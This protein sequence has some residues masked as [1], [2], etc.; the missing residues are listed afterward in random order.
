M[1]DSSLPNPGF[2]ARAATA[3]VLDVFGV[4]VTLLAGG[5]GTNG[6][7]SIARIVCLPGTGAPRHRHVEAE[8]FH[9]LRGR[10]TVHLDGRDHTL[11]PGDLVHVAPRAVHDF[12]NLASE[13]AEFVAL[14]MP[15]G[16]EDFFRDADELARS[17]RFTPETAGALCQRH[18]IELLP[19]G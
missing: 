18:G 15:S 5:D 13:P 9:V 12:R 16:H 8:T 17:G 2:I 10:L 14:G 11:E 7:C 19:P 6:A 1:N 4:Q 3:P